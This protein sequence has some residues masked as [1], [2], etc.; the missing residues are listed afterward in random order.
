[1]N[2]FGR[3]ELYAA[4][5]AIGYGSAYV[6]TAFALRSFDPLPVAIYRSSLAAIGLVAML[7]VLRSLPSQAAPIAPAAGRPRAAV[8]IAHLAVIAAFG[9]P[10]FFGAMNLAV[11]GVGATIASFV[12][13]LYAILAAL[14][15]P[16]LLAERLR[17]RALAGFVAA[18]VG[19]ALL[20]ELDLGRAGVAGIGWGLVAAVSFAL[21]LVLSRKWSGPDGL[22]PMVVALSNMVATTVVLGAIVVVSDPGSF[23]PRPIVLEAVLAVAWLA[24]VASVGQTL[25]V[26]AV[27]LLRASRSS[28]FLLLNPIA[29]TI[30]SVLLLGEQPTT[31][32]ALG[33]LLVLVGIA[34]TTI[35]AGSGAGPDL[36]ARGDPIR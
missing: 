28:A 26:R 35:P 15:A 20:A 32:Q 24:V 2:Q 9:G 33:G 4:L 1:M 23:A 21:F 18:L 36:I 12:A 25:A 3:G 19:T 7:T 31:V 27:R 16:F 5:A 29:A 30:L 34:V 22:D 13:G 17:P 10:I 6:A 8:R 11:S 14:F